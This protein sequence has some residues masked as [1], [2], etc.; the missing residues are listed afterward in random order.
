MHRADWTDE[1]LRQALET[2]LTSQAMRDK[3]AATGAHMQGANGTEKAARLLD[4]L[5]RSTRDGD[6]FA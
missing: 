3:L 4:G 5:L 1:Q 2:L 6:D